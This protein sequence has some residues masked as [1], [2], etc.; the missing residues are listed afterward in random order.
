MAIDLRE[1][2]TRDF[3]LSRR[4]AIVDCFTSEGKLIFSFPQQSRAAARSLVTARQESET[5]ED[6]DKEL[7]CTGLAESLDAARERR[8]QRAARRLR[9]AV[10]ANLHTA[11]KRKYG[12]GTAGGPY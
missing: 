5:E 6:W 9:G 8:R 2:I 11:R 3:H 10:D 1:S 12:Q 7:D 4:S